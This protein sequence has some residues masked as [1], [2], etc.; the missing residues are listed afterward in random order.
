M[1]VVKVVNSIIPPWQTEVKSGKYDFLNTNLILDP[2]KVFRKS[3]K[4]PF[5][6]LID[7]ICDLWQI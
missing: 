6:M 7:A 3:F 5:K 2:L 1:E 4:I